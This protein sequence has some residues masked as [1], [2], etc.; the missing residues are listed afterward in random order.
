MTLGARAC[1]FFENR[2]KDVYAVLVIL[3]LP[4]LVTFPWLLGF[5]SL[6]PV[7]FVSGLASFR[8]KQILPEIAVGSPT[9]FAVRLCLKTHFESDENGS[10]RCVRFFRGPRFLARL[11]ARIS[12]RRRL[13]LHDPQRTNSYK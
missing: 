7:H 13:F 6:D 5:W 4:I 1:T 10:F 3:L 8:G 11:S 12:E 9:A 2:N